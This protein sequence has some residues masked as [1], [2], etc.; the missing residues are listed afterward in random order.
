MPPEPL[1]VWDYERLA[2][3]KLDPGAY[4]YFAG[5]AGDE[6]TLDDNVAAFRRLKLRPR[7]LVDVSAVT[8][9]ADV[10]GQRVSMP[11]LVAPMA[12]QRL[13]H[14]DGECATARAAARAGAIFCLSTIATA[15]APEIAEAAP[16]GQRW[17][18]LYVFRDRGVT[19]ELL[20]EAVD[21]NFSAVLLTVD[22]PRSGRRERDLRT[23]VRIPH[24]VPSIVRALGS[25]E[26]LRPEDAVGGVLAQD[27]SWRDVEAIAESS[28]LPVLVKGVLTHEDALLACESGAAG[29]VVSNHGGRQLDGVEASIEALPE[30][31]EAV[32]GRVPVLMD[33]G[34]RRG[35]DIVKALALGAQAVLAGRPFVWGLAVDGENGVL[36][37]L[38]LLRAELELALALLGCTSPAEVTPAHVSRR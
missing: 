6:V 23:G 37:V 24:H 13:A 31:V 25:A 20:A 32:A 27:V 30:V 28:G 10:L 8:T 11:L 35:T 9:E 7:V 26:G 18:Q 1:N 2:E 29:V 3:E 5:G 4:G 33:G 14:P 17:L 21:A 19:N 34:V 15:A 12:Y 16:E 22:L 38:E 36:R